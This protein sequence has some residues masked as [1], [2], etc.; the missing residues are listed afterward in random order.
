[1]R[2]TQ[3]P[4]TTF[5]LLPEGLLG[6]TDVSPF[7]IGTTPITNE[8]YRA[9]DPSF[10]PAPASPGPNH[11]AVAVT[12]AEARAY[13]EWYGE[14]AKKPIRLPTDIEW[15]YACRAGSVTRT[16]FKDDGDA[17]VWDAE[18]SAGQAAEVGKKRANAN[19]LYDM[20]GLVWEWTSDGSLR[21]GS[22]REARA[23]LDCGLRRRADAALRSDDVGFRIVRS[24]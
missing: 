13:C 22:F 17:Y 12:L 3:V 16:F 11:P 14:L 1:V 10:K 24:L 18:N 7:Y 4:R 21:G 8:Q 2:Y 23:S 9:F 20:L 6:D 15:E 19:G 5:W